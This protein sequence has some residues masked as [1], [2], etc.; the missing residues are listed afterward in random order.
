MIKRTAKLMILLHLFF[1]PGIV[2]SQAQ[3][4]PPEKKGYIVGTILSGLGAHPD[5]SKTQGF[6]TCLEIIN[7]GI[8][9]WSEHEEEIHDAAVSLPLIFDL[10]VISRYGFG[11]TFGDL[12]TISMNRNYRDANHLYFGF[13]YVHSIKEWDIGASFIIFPVYVTGDE[14]IAG[15]IDTSYWLFKD[16]GITLST[17]LGGTIGWAHARVVLFAASMGI[18]VKI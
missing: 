12:L 15:K 2:F 1:I 6:G 17:I 13:S 16:I 3:E 14:L 10:K 8:V 7:R 9:D 18:S 5:R 4:K 11:F